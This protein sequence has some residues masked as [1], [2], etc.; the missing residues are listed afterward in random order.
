MIRK[1]VT[2]LTASPAQM[3][4]CTGAAPRHRGSKEKCRLIQPPGTASS[5]ACGKS[6][7]KA[8]TAATSASRART[9]AT[10]SSSAFAGFSTGRPSWSARL[11]TGEAVSFLPRPA[12]ASGRVSTATIS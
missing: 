12:G 1:A 5:N 7:P 4:R 9:W 10:S 3:A 8:T 2:P 11:A 6:M